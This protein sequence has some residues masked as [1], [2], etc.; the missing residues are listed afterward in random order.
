MFEYEC[1]LTNIRD[2]AGI[3]VA[4][5]SAAARMVELSLALTFRST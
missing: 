4:Y 3:S 2:L 1:A 5:I